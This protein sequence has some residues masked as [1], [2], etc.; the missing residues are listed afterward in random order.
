MP[1]AQTPRALNVA[2]YSS[3]HLRVLHLL[4]YFFSISVSRMDG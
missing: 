2:P 4:L 3:S 1:A